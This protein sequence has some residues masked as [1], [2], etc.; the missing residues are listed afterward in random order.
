MLCSPSN[1]HPPQFGNM[2]S[3]LFLLVVVIVYRFFLF[4]F[5]FSVAST[6][7][8]A[9]KAEKRHMP[10]SGTLKTNRLSKRN[11][12]MRS[13]YMTVCMLS[14][15]GTDV[16]VVVVVVCVY[17]GGKGPGDGTISR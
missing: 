17:G 7:K 2:F 12:R 13:K 8:F 15:N 11:V 14:C 10:L 6:S 9:E 4:L 3:F 16:C 5:F 1:L